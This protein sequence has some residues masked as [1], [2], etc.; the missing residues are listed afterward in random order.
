MRALQRQAL[1]TFLALACLCTAS[2]GAAP[3]PTEVARLLLPLTVSVV[4][5]YR[6][7][8]SAALLS[9]GTANLL[10]C[11]GGAPGARQLLQA[12][13]AAG[14]PAATLA[15]LLGPAEPSADAAAGTPTGSSLPVAQLSR[16]AAAGGAPAP[17]A[18]AAAGAPAAQP[19]A[20]PVAAPQP[21]L[22]AAA[23]PTGA[24]LFPAQPLALPQGAPEAPAAAAGP[25]AGGALVSVSEAAVAPAPSGPAASKRADIQDTLGAKAGAFTDATT[26]FLAGAGLRE[27]ILRSGS[28]Q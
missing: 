16:G 27:R 24:A 4:L 18:A 15:S 7:K 9:A 1:A 21:A 5:H 8:L 6:R 11:C 26:L 12:D 14:A 13:A 25:G 22:A 17:V 3:Y 2:Q 28:L 10:C 23:A 19:P 20:A